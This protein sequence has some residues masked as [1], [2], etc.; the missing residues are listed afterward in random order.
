MTATVVGQASETELGEI[1]RQE[2]WWAHIEVHGVAVHQLL[3]SPKVT[4]LG[5][6]QQSIQGSGIRLDRSKLNSKGVRRH[7]RHRRQIGTTDRGCGD[8][9]SFGQVSEIPKEVQLQGLATIAQKATRI[10]AVDASIP[11]VI[12]AVR[13]ADLPPATKRR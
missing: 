2:T 13:A 10:T 3:G 7:E 8:T 9:D 11:A 1:R 12:R 5:Q 6:M 4:G